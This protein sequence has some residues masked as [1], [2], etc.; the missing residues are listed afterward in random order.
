MDSD[1]KAMS[2]DNQAST[3]PSVP[4]GTWPGAFGLYKYSKA[5]IGF[6]VWTIVGL[7]LLQIVA[8]AIINTLFGTDNVNK[9]EPQPVANFLSWIVGAIFGIATIAAVFAGIARQKFSLGN[10]F[11]A[12]SLGL[13]G[14]YLLLSLVQGAILILSL[15]LFIV[16]FFFVAPRLALAT[17]FLV[18]KNAG[19]LEALS[20]S[21]NATKGNVGKVYGVVGAFIAFGLLCLTIIGIPFAV[22]FMVAYGAAIALLYR[23]VLAQSPEASTGVDT[24]PTI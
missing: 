10:A 23:Y 22:Y 4:S 21:W 16:P 2:P 15:V 6:N 14:K 11:G 24:A 19:P 3:L 12:V 9:P 7:I 8:G 13:F 18:D 1:T 17:Y 5:A 20:L